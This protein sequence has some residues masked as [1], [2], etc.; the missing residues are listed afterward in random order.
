MRFAAALIVLA[1]CGDDAVDLTGIY[2]V[3]SAIGSTPCGVDDV[4]ANIPP[5]LKFAKDEFLGQDYFK[6]DGCTDEAGTD[7]SSAPGLFSG[8]FE[9][10][11]DGWRSIVTSSS[12]AG[13]R[14]ALQYDEQT[15]ILKNELLVIDG[16]TFRD[17]VDLPDS[18]CE[19][20]EAERR[21]KSMPCVTHS[22]IDATRLTMSR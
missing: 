16:S 2:R 4:L 22:R 15:A 13:G 11:S 21:N 14:C 6:F 12:G 5:F 20:E 7:C 18:K 8:F 3:D 1:A 9:P 19:P 10:I 17:T